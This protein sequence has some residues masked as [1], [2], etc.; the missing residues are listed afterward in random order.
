M[1]TKQVKPKKRESIK[2]ARFFEELANISDINQLKH[3][4]I[5]LLK[6]CK[7]QRELIHRLEDMMVVYEDKFNVIKK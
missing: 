6:L 4:F 3:E 7:A 5:T 1:K 2:M